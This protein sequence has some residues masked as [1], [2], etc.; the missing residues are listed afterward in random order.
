MEQL[1]EQLYKLLSEEI[2][3]LNMGHMPNK[4]R[5][6]KM[7]FLCEI[8]LFLRYTNLTSSEIVQI[9]NLVTGIS[10]H[11]VSP[12]RMRD[13]EDIITKS[14]FDIIFDENTNLIDQS[15]F[16]KIFT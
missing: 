1:K 3:N 6:R 4:V 13:F 16:D 9:I 15:E 14:E 8:L 11:S 10:I 7:K 12:K 5:L 2:R